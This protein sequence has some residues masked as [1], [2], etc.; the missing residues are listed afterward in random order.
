MLSYRKF[1]RVKKKKKKK[2]VKTEMNPFQD[3]NLYLT[4]NFLSVS[5]VNSRCNQLITTFIYQK[6]KP[7][8]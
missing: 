2:K 6:S 8:D 7:D 5:H 1:K 4:F 3:Q